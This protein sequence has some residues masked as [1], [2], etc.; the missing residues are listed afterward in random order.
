MPTTGEGKSLPLIRMRDEPT[1]V[2][3]QRVRVALRCQQ[4][5]NPMVYDFRDVAVR[6]GHD[7]HTGGEHLRDRYRDSALGIAVARGHAWRQEDVVS[8]RLVQQ[9]TMRLI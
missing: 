2:C 6:G 7:R 1:H 8:I 4:S 9:H 3:R 5:R